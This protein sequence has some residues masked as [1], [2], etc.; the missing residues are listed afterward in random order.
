MRAFHLPPM[1]REVRETGHGV[2]GIFM[3]ATL[4][5]ISVLV[6]S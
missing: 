6:K 3:H 4:T 1:T 5:K 2:V